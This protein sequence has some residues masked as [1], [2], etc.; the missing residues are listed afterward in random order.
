M[1]STRPRVLTLLLAH[2]RKG[3]GIDR[4]VTDGPP[5]RQLRHAWQPVGL[6]R[7]SEPPD[8]RRHAL[9]G[10]AW[11]VA[12]GAEQTVPAR[13]I[14]PEV[15]VGLVIVDRLVDAMP[16]GGD[17]H[18]AQQPVDVIW[19]ADVGVVEYRHT[20][21]AL[22][23]PQPCVDAEAA[24]PI[25]ASGNNRRSIR[26]LRAT[27]PVLSAQLSPLGWLNRRRGD[28]RSH[29]ATAVNTS[30]KTR[31]RIANSLFRMDSLIQA[32]CLLTPRLPLALTSA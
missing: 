24:L 9:V 4:I 29:P 22:N 12:I 13:Q 3:A 8:A 16:V 23:R 32:V 15:C 19:Q 21:K 7:L 14:A 28:S 1:R 30:A 25:A 11:P 31:S 2:G 10:G 6:L 20:V 17:H 18:Q 5:K 26:V 27:R